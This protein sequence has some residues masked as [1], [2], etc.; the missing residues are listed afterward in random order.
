MLQ[1]SKCHIGLAAA[2]VSLDV[3]LIQFNAFARVKECNSIVLHAEVGE[4]TVAV[5]HCFLLIRNFAKDGLGV[6]IDSLVK[7]AF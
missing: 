5:V 4:G 2:V 3:G 6:L 7:F 1:L